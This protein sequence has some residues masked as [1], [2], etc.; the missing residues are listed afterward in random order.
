MKLGVRPLT[1]RPLDNKRS[2][3]VVDDYRLQHLIEH[4][5]VGDDFVE[6]F[7][8]G[9]VLSD[10]LNRGAIQTAIRACIKETGGGELF[11]ADRAVEVSER[12]VVSQGAT[13]T[14]DAAACDF[15]SR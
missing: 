10:R 11:S 2:L 12:R 15:R 9:G 7:D 4:R 8:P 14:W 5:H 6:F 1:G 13:A 3:G